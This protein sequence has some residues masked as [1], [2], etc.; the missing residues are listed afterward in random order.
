M[1]QIFH[2][3]YVL[4]RLAGIHFFGLFG[5]AGAEVLIEGLNE[6][7]ERIVKLA[8]HKLNHMG[9][10]ATPALIK[11]LNSKNALIQS[12]AAKLLGNTA[13]E[14]VSSLSQAMNSDNEF[15]R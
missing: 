1:F 3:I 12:R 7:D 6:S 9:D 15:V 14:S 5:R 13:P 11:A 2:E 10:K 4:L 8:E